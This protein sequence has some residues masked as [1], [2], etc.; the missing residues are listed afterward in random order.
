MAVWDSKLISGFVGTVASSECSD[1]NLISQIQALVCTVVDIDSKG[2]CIA[3][4]LLSLIH[5]HQNI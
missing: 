4:S 1:L 5:L 2:S 3:L